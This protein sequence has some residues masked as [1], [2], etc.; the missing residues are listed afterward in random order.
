MQDDFINADFA[1]YYFIVNERSLLAQLLPNVKALFVLEFVGFVYIPF[2][3][4]A[5]HSGKPLF[6]TIC[7]SSD[8][9]VDEVNSTRK[10]RKRTVLLLQTRRVTSV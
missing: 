4:E 8:P 9:S 7:I 6:L 2:N 1:N 5:S 3:L 10:A